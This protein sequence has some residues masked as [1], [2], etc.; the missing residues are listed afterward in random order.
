MSACKPEHTTVII[1]AAG[2]GTRLGIGT[3]KALVDISGTPLIIRQLDLLKEYDDIR[4]VVG[5]QA[6]RLIEVVKKYRKD[7]MFV[8]NYQ[9]ETSGVADSLRKGL[10]ATRN[11]II[12]ID[13]DILF[14]PDDFKVFT[15]CDEE[16][17]VVSDVSTAEPIMA[18]VENEMAIK[19]S[20]VEGNMQWP[21]IVKIK[22][23]KLKGKS[24]KVYDVLNEVLPL[25]VF[26]MRTREI[27]TQE[28]Y[29]RAIE[30]FEKGQVD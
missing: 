28:D 14:N 16:C 26:K 5:F 3:T 27:N 29:D 24:P 13:G 23:E 17:L 11:Y 22:S 19:L 12:S 10:L 18:T 30:W 4:I 7:I 25:R 6:E 21:G 8:F 2:M 20:K 1:C 9:Y 15:S